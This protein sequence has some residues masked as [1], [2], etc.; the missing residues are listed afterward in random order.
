LK[1]ESEFQLQPAIHHLF[2][3]HDPRHNEA[4]IFKNEISSDLL[5][6]CTAK[7]IAYHKYHKCVLSSTYN[8]NAK[9]PRTKDSKR[10]RILLMVDTRA[11]E[12][13]F[14]GIHSIML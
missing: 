8:L 9:D 5:L 13:I 2:V 6:K 11:I 12:L 4:W 7:C 1:I 3:L 14:G 10:V